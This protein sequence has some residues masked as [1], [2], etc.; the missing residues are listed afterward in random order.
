MRMGIINV[1]YYGISKM[2]KR[3]SEN[4]EEKSEKNISDFIDY[5]NGNV[6]GYDAGIGRKYEL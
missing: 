3:K 6:S 2:V 4:E 5:S 1:V